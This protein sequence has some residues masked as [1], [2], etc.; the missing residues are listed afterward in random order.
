M[1][2]RRRKLPTHTKMLLGF[3]L[4]LV[5]GIIFRSFPILEPESLTWTVKNVAKPAG[6]LFLNLIFMVVVPLLFSALVLGVAEMGD[7]KR[8]G[9]IGVRSLLLTLVLSSIA[10]GI[11]LAAVNLVKPGQITPEQRTALQKSYNKEDTEKKVKQSQETKSVAETLLDL[12]PKNPL[13]SATKALEGGLLPFMVFALIFGI[14]LGAIDPEKSL[15]VK[16][17]LEGLFAASL[18][19]IEYAMAYGP[20]GVFFLIFAATADLGLDALFAVAKYALLVLAALAF[21]LIFTYGL[22]IRF[23][24]KRNPVQYFKSLSG[25][26]LTAFTTSSSNATLPHALK[27]GEEQLGLPKQINS[28]V[29]TIGA[30]ANQNGTALFEGITVLFLAQLFGV[31]LSIG[32]QLLVMGLS[33]VAGIGTAGVPG[34]SWPMIAI[35]VGMIGLDP[36]AIGLCIGVDRI[37]D[38]SR[39]VLNVTGDLTIATV[40]SDWEGARLEPELG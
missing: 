32:Q 7:A 19:V 36:M 5:V 6:T 33:I 21:H 34:G 11:G 16:S 2:E 17:F 37:L 1:S 35:V 30:T 23:F 38:M 9:R 26:M 31:D 24:T 13:E 20:I 39:T 22:V 4:G 14:A 40:V 3:I 15:P 12:V 8:L 18:K 27:A 10:V 25:V 29:L 28:F